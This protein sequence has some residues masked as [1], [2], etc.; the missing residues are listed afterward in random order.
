MSNFYPRNLIRMIPDFPKPGIKFRDVMPLIS[1]GFA[2]QEVTKEM[3]KDFINHDIN[4]VVG[5]EARGFIFGAAIARLLGAGFVPLRKPG[6]LP[7]PVV[8][9]GYN[10]EYGSDKLEM[11]DDAIQEGDRTLLVDDLLATGGTA[12]AAL[13]LL[14]LK[15]ATIMGCSFLIELTGLPGRTRL[16]SMGYDPRVVYTFGED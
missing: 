8:S 7:G 11:Q 9:F 10:L 1:D 12:A 4:K 2:F 3:A 6:K 5:M 13:H 16:Q 14:E 15:K